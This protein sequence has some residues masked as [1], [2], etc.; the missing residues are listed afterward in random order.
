M[1]SVQEL[2]DKKNCLVKFGLPKK[3]T[4]DESYNCEC[5]ANMLLKNCQKDGICVLEAGSSGNSFEI[6][7]GKSIE[8]N[9]FFNEIDNSKILDPQK[10]FNFNRF[11]SRYYHL[12]GIDE[13]HNQL[14]DVEDKYDNMNLNQSVNSKRQILI[15]CMDNYDFLTFDENLNMMQLASLIKYIYKADYLTIGCGIMLENEH[16]LVAGLKN[17]CEVVCH[18][19]LKGGGPKN[20]GT[21]SSDED[22]E[23]EDEN[24][25]EVVEDNEEEEIRENIPEDLEQYDIDLDN[26]V[27]E[28]E[29]WTGWMKYGELDMIYW[30]EYDEAILREYHDEY[31]ERARV[32][33]EEK[34]KRWWSKEKTRWNK[35]DNIYEKTVEET[36]WYHMERTVIYEKGWVCDFKRWRKARSECMSLIIRIEREIR[37]EFK[38]KN[39]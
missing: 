22:E 26:Y 24:L 17:D 25:Y 28:P 19:W 38:E 14:K 9:H 20:L 21:S 39:F 13:L 37:C 7:C 35:Y 29:E 4:S 1:N 30:Y 32:E 34:I 3:S 6:R 36:I 8:R 18:Y 23:E 31:L 33:V 5:T 12:K 2:A 10:S 16:A 27:L 11:A 15:R